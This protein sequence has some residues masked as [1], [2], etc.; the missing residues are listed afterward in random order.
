M[1]SP[2]RVAEKAGPERA[3][4]VGTAAAN[5]TNAANVLGTTLKGPLREA[6]MKTSEVG[7]TIEG[8][9]FIGCRLNGEPMAHD[10]PV[11]LGN[12]NIAFPQGWTAEMVR[13]FVSRG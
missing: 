1:P 9:F 6:D 11:M 2:A 5:P 10:E 13:E 3:G 8:C 12:G 7:G 4:E